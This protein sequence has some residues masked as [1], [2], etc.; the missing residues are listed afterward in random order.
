M[1]N[2]MVP[3]KLRTEKEMKRDSIWK[4]AGM[5]AIATAAMLATTHMATGSRQDDGFSTDYAAFT[6]ELSAIFMQSTDK[7]RSESVVAE[8]R[9]F[10]QSGDTKMA[11][12]LIETSNRIRKLKGKAYPDY[13]TAL[14]T[15][16]TMSAN[17]RIEGANYTV[18]LKVLE[19]KKKRLNTLKTF[20][21]QTAAY[22]TNGTISST[23]AVAWRVP[24]ASKV[25]FVE[26]DGDINY[27]VSETTLR[28][29]SQGDS[30][31]VERTSGTL[32]GKTKKWLGDHGLITWERTG[33]DP[34]KVRA[35]FGYYSIDTKTNQVEVGECEFVNLNYFAE[36]LTG[37]VTYK[38]LNRK[39]QYGLRY[40][41]FE[42]S[43]GQRM[44]IKELFKNVGYRGGF[45]QTGTSFVGSG[46]VWLPAEVNIHRGDTVLATFSAASFLMTPT[47]VES[48]KTAVDITLGT[49][50]MTHPGLRFRFDDKKRQVELTRGNN[51]TERA[52]Y[53]D[54]YHKVN[55]D[56][57]L[58]QWD[59]DGSHLFM[60]QLAGS[61]MN[62]A[63]VE[64]QAYYADDDFNRLWGMADTH[65][66]QT[67]A[68]FVRYNGGGGFPVRDFADFNNMTHLQAQQLLLSL[69]YDGFVDYY[70]ERDVCRA[71]DRLYDY[72]KFSL[73]KKDYDEM[74]FLSVDSQA[75]EP[76][77][78][79]DL[80]TLDIN[81]RKVYGVQI[82]DVDNLNIYLKPTDGNLTLKRNR[83]I[84]Y[85]GI[86]TV[87]QVTAIGR[88]FFFDYDNFQIRMDS[89]DEMSMRM[90]DS[91]KMDRQGRYLTPTVGNTLNDLSG[92]V[93]L[94]EP[95]N[96][97]GKMKLPGYP[98]LS[99]T[100][101][102]KIYYDK[103]RLT[104][105]D[106]RV[107]IYDK[108]RFYFLVDT[109]TFEDIN[110]IS[111][112]N[113]PL[114]GVLTS[115]I[116]PDI[117]HPLRIREDYSLGFTVETPAEGYPIYGDKARFYKTIDLSNQGLRGIGE[118]TY[119]A[120]K[121]RSYAQP[122]A[123]GRLTG[124]GRD[125]YFRF[126]LDH[127]EGNARQ[128]DVKKST[129]APTF[130]G[131]E[132]GEGQSTRDAN[133]IPQPG[134][135]QLKL[136]P[137][138]DK[139]DARNV[140]GKFQMF[141]K[142]S[143]DGYECEMDGK[144]TVTPG[145]L[146]GVGRNDMMGTSLEGRRISFTDHVIKAD[147]SY[148]A[149]YTYE[150]E[151][152]ILQSGEL[153]RDIV[154]KRDRRI[155]GRISAQTRGRFVNNA[156]REDSVMNKISREDKSVGRELVNRSME[157]IIDFDKR[158]GYFQFIAEG[159][160]EKE[161]STIKYKTM[162]KN[163]TWDLERNI[164]TIGTKGSSGNR[165]VCTKERGDSLQF[166]VP[167]AIFDRN[168]N[169]LQCEEV[170][171]I[172][173][174]D[175]RVNLKAG[176][177][178][179][180]R[181]NAAMDEL[182]DTKVD[183]A[184]DSTRHEFAKANI[185]IGG[186]K[187]YKGFGE[188]TF[189]DNE[190]GQ[191]VIFMGDIHTDDAVTV[192]RGNVPDDMPLDKHFLFKGDTE[193]RGNRQ[194]LNFD[195]GAKM[196]H[197]AQHG[198]RGY[199]RFTSIVNPARVRIPVGARSFDT[200]QGTSKEKADEIYHSFRI[201]KDST[202]IY[203]TM[204]EHYK[205]SSDLE[206]VE[207]PEGYL[208]HNNIFD[209]FEINSP[210]KIANPDT[211][212]TFLYFMPEQDAVE[213]FGRIDLRAFLTKTPTGSF[214]IRSAGTIKDDRSK[215]L[216]TTD[217]FTEMD[218]FIGPEVATMIYEDILNS[219]APKCDSTSYRYERRLAELYDTLSISGIRNEL[220]AGLDPQT[221]MLPSFGPVFGMDGMNFTWSTGKKSYVC[222]TTVNLMMMH[223][224]K[225]Y[226]K[227]KVQC[228]ILV[229]KN[230]GSRVRMLL[231]PDADT[232]YYID[233]RGGS[234]RGYNRLNLLS[235]NPEL[236]QTVLAIDMKE[237][238]DRSRNMEYSIAPESYYEKFLENFGLDRIPDDAYAEAEAE[239]IMDG[240]VN[241]EEEQLTMDN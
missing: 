165:F 191:N 1:A 125:D 195:G 151:E 90:V 93:Q 33:L 208:Y 44:E 106:G 153:R 218:F 99:S 212:G 20:L 127:T 174:A 190:G 94:N 170:K 216:I 139:L 25:R 47:T 40:P 144:L 198:P 38:C 197:T 202:H 110:S 210:A 36:K 219:K 146:L 147:T 148:F 82:S 232:W 21:D 57:E 43:E 69:S 203:S 101:P 239:D 222:D 26:A 112:S 228:E 53:R 92:I 105:E 207:A 189:V 27:E 8:L 136:F 133:N 6:E 72:L 192:A 118:L 111:N 14:H 73:G 3:Q 131:V 231:K 166:L 143:G 209:R 162:V 70:V 168:T 223:Y 188:Y 121:A 23:S 116:F 167:V 220:E 204:L 75:A 103:N 52:K 184:T 129:T 91:T 113:L 49:E 201:A 59:I 177:L 96:K 80:N 109:F 141:P 114:N 171:F 137:A 12:L 31:D 64:S 158:E 145:G 79:I 205:L 61:P 89:I 71:T 4:L 159:G 193:V 140:V 60:T 81:M 128:F 35:T 9:Q 182:K 241:E 58:I 10:M 230:N 180:I 130:P 108:E 161:F 240:V 13:I 85:D 119:S 51:G 18:W 15:F 224:R 104:G 150:N 213:A 176:D 2:G 179:T 56:A 194:L 152:R 164:E 67:I 160:N 54:S 126:F 7:K 37:K 66:F 183:V 237:R 214:D 157:S 211:T 187:E 62:R 41:R 206:M 124:Y 229:R 199:I 84:E 227:V 135:T 78:Y 19:G 50:S 175:A 39:T 134:K 17:P 169:V 226:R 221:N 117:R 217:L 173:V 29:M 22:A 95:D 102:A 142:K 32:Y 123:E 77:G 185:T 48:T 24:D 181:K 120:S 163:Y 30:I 178:V 74:R 122:D 236:S 34:E 5:A 88:H 155:Y 149:S 234:G 76:N 68:D 156:I 132:L 28:C 55:L 107:N 225:V 215:N 115:N 100:K 42:T 97:S 83:D 138:E 87:G 196:R 186:A 46:S 235:S 233:F 65:P 154:D 11:D 172:D 238:R 45:T 86:V 200:T 98:R 16:E 63:Y